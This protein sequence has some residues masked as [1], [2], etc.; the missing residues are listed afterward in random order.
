MGRRA[1]GL[2]GEGEWVE[3]GLNSRRGGRSC[4]APGPREAT[5]PRRQGRLLC[6]GDLVAKHLEHEGRELHAALGLEGEG[7]VLLGMLLV[8]AAQVR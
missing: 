4:W 6:S 1:D 3:E 2:A 5:P 8:Q 7:A